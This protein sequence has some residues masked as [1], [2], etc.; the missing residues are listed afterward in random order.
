MS[1]KMNEQLVQ[2]LRERNMTITTVESLTG[3]LIASTIVDVAGAS[4]VLKEA[5]VTY[6]DEA[7]HKLAGESEETLRRYTAVSEQTA[8]EMAEGGARAAKAN[9]AISATG[10]AGPD[11]G[12]PECPVGTVYIGCT[13]AGR[14]EI[15]ELHLTGDRREIR[16]AAAREGIALACGML[17]KM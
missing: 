7:K 3:G 12:T 2:L 1:N 14:T 9:A 11:G 16:E 13:A 6:C 4:D 15:R 17:E 10:L 5:Y 8:R